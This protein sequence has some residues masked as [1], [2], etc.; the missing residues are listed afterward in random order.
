[1]SYDRRD[2]PN[3]GIVSAQMTWGQFLLGLV[4]GAV[5]SL[6]VLALSAK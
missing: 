4:L 5:L 6:I 2:D 1:M 3:D